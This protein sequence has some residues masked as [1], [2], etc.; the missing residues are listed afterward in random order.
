M[1]LRI[2]ITLAALSCFYILGMSH[3]QNR[4]ITKQIKEIKYVQ[5]QNAAIHARP[6]A[7]R[8]ELLNLMR[9]GKL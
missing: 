4:V 5:T 6:H 8:D 1:W 7:S 3:C 2:I 9:R